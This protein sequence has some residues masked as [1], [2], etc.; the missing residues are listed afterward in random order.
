MRYDVRILIF[1]AY[2]HPL[3]GQHRTLSITGSQRNTNGASTDDSSNDDSS[4]DNS[5]TISITFVQTGQKTTLTVDNYVSVLN[6]VPAPVEPEHLYAQ[7][8]D[9]FDALGGESSDPWSKVGSH[10][11]TSADDDC[12][13]DGPDDRDVVAGFPYVVNLLMQTRAQLQS[14]E[15]KHCT[16][17]IISP[18]WVAT[19]ESCCKDAH[20][21]VLDFD[22]WR[23][24]D[25]GNG[26]TGRM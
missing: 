15:G 19:S 6:L 2:V 23:T 25:D 8:V 22:D 11:A 18:Y 20:M 21:A 3:K 12:Q 4:T 10:G 1:L 13:V 9:G 5:A 14:S 24:G 26:S 7:S 16:A 17:T